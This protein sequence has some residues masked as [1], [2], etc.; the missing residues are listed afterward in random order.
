MSGGAATA[1]SQVR[2]ERIVSAATAIV[3]EEGVDTAT[4]RAI[5]A[6]GGVLPRL[7]QRC[8]TATAG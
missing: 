4:P 7:R 6:R 3:D 5:A 8:G 1:R 2:V